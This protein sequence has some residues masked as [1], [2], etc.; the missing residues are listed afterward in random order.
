MNSSKDFDRIYTKEYYLSD[1]SGYKE[2]LKGEIAPRYLKALRLLTVPRRSMLLDVGCGRGELL[3]LAGKRGMRAVGVDISTEAL[4]LCDGM[5]VRASA[6]FLPFRAKSFD[7]ISLLDVLEHFEAARGK[8]TLL[9]LRRVCSDNGSVV[10]R[11]PNKWWRV[12][13]GL[14]QAVFLR[15]KK[16][17]DI[18]Q[19]LP[20]GHRQEYN[21]MT[22]VRLFLQTGFVPVP[23][24]IPSMNSSFKEFTE[25]IPLF[26]PS[27]IWCVLRKAKWREERNS[28]IVST[29]TASRCFPLVS[30]IGF[31]LYQVVRYR[32]EERE[33]G[34]R[35][36]S[37]GCGIGH[38]PNSWSKSIGTG[39]RSKQYSEP[40]CTGELNGSR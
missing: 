21:P 39:S 29:E 34:Q 6:E 11:T 13:S 10:V 37:L 18:F 14:V 30:N 2:F 16:W 23:T 25:V 28:L 38:R 8:N 15:K 7:A 19:S 31:V 9:E 35:L 26:S 17:R 3:H 36:F 33:G 27:S 24:L 40:H 22:L 20:T 5:R 12:F 4:G 1:C 32:L